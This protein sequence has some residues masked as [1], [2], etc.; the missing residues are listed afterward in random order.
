MDDRILRMSKRELRE[1]LLQ[2]EQKIALQA[3]PIAVR[4]RLLS[5]QIESDDLDV[6]TW[7]DFVTY[8]L[9][10]QRRATFEMII[11]ESE[12]QD[13][14]SSRFTKMFV[15]IKEHTHGT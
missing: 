12:I 1:R 6:S 5:F 8:R 11:D 3:A 7:G 9:H 15:E 10:R 14:P 13:F 2:A 4:G